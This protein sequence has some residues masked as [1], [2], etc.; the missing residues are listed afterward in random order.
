MKRKEKC[1]TFK[2]G[3]VAIDL[4]WVVVILFLLAITSVVCYKLFGELNT[5]IQADEDVSNSTKLVVSELHGRY[6]STFDA[7]FVLAFALFWLMLVYSAFQINSNPAFFAISLILMIFIFIAFMFLGN[8]YEE[9]MQDDEF[10]SFTSSF[11]MTYFI[12]THMLETGI[13]IGMTI[14]LALYAKTKVGS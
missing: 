5:D 8:S 10:A 12:M 4:A 7:I 2:R 3:N 11:P 9:F 14:M 6:P 13:M 1:L